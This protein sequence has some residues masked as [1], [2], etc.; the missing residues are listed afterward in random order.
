MNLKR[1]G[2]FREMP[3]GRQE[4]F[5]IQEA[6]G[7]LAEEIQS[8]VVS[9]LEHG[10][11][12]I[13]CAG[14]AEDIINPERGCSGSPGVLTD[15]RWFW[16]GDLAYYVRNYKVKLPEEFIKT[17]EENSWEISISFDDLDLE[18]LSLEGEYVFR[19]M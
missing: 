5:S 18:E 7:K 2:Y 4:D 10:I 9:Y 13:S 1:Q 15:G 16:P 8:K 17:M 12:I 6:V 11:E 19:G 3:H 14:M